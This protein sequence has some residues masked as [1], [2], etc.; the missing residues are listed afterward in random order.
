MHMDSGVINRLLPKKPSPLCAGN[1]LALCIKTFGLVP[2]AEPPRL[3]KSSTY[4]AKALP[5]ATS[6]TSLDLGENEIG[7][8]GAAAILEIARNNPCFVT[9]IKGLVNSA[10]INAVVENN[11]N[12]LANQ[13]KVGAVSLVDDHRMPVVLAGLVASYIAPIKIND[14]RDSAGYIGDIR[15]ECAGFLVDSALPGVDMKEEGVEPLRAESGLSDLDEEEVMFPRRA[16]SL[17][18]P[19]AAESLVAPQAA[20]SLL[21]AEVVEQAPAEAAISLN[22]E[23]EPGSENDHKANKSC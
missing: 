21:A 8:A 13:A 11:R 14:N 10:E 2:A 15:E 1:N 17:V 22:D 18:V 7:D 9:E 5:A 12:N 19:E 3:S 16:D 4:L 23:A 6:L 20:G